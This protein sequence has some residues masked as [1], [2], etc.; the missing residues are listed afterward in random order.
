MSR[1]NQIETIRNTF[2]SVKNDRLQRLYPNATDSPQAQPW[3]GWPAEDL[4]TFVN[5]T[6]SLLERALEGELLQDAPH[7]LLQALTQNLT[8][9]QRHLQGVPDRGIQNQHHN[10]LA[11]LQA[12]QQQLRAFGYYTLIK[13]QP[14][15]PDTVKSVEDQLRRLS[16][17]NKDV[18]A[19]RGQVESLVAPAL[20]S[21]LSKA[22]DDRR[23]T[24]ARAKLAWGVLS[25]IGVVL[26]AWQAIELTDLLAGFLANSQATGANAAT[27]TAAIVVRSLAVLPS[28]FA[29]SF[30]ISQYLRERKYEEF[31]ANKS[32]VATSLPSYSELVTNTDVKDQITTSATAVVFEKPQAIERRLFQRSEPD[33]PSDAT[34]AADLLAYVR[35]ILKAAQGT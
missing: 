1:A 28:G 3:G 15:L 14:T 27:V 16:E 11:Q 8:Q 2:E 18:Q 29:V 17:A 32:A 22:F 12:I 4:E 6:M 5:E 19:L 21:S 25:V 7:N 26:F 23:A 10:A 31:Y 35:D 24:V 20:A 33:P 34:S 13:L 9:F 30:V